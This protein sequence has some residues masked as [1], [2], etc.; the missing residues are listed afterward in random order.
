MITIQN[1]EKRF[2]GR[3]T[4]AGVNVHIHEGERVAIVGVSGVGKST[5]LRCINALESFDGGKIEIAGFELGPGASSLAAP[6][7]VRLRSAV[8]MVFQEHHLF[9]HLTALQ[10]VT[11]A[12]RVVRKMSPGDAT[13]RANILLDQVGL[14]DRKGAYPDSL[15]GGQRQ[16]VAIARALAQEPRVLLLDEPTSA[17]DAVTAESVMKTIA[18]VVGDSVTVVL[19]T[20]QPRIAEFIATRTL[21]LEGGV[22]V[23]AAAN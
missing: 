13:R 9:P 22:L 3:S 7:L 23:D 20:H 17:L 12:P 10:N 4:L 21:R 8:G 15:S 19:V 16:R 5:L 14:A 11:L 1:L 18:D 6:A 2:G